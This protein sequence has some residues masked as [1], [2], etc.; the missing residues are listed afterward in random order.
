MTKQQKKKLK[1]QKP[2]RGNPPL[3]LDF[4]RKFIA[5]IFGLMFINMLFTK[6]LCPKQHHKMEYSTRR[7]PGHSQ[8]RTLMRRFLLCALAIGSTIF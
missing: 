5:K 3:G 1:R 7:I 2:N 8:V 6:L 4:V